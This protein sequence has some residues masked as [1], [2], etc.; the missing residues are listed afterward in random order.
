MKLGL[1]LPL[2]DKNMSDTGTFCNRNS[3]ANGHIFWKTMRKIDLSDTLWEDLE[4]R[5]VLELENYSFWTAE[6]ERCSV[7]DL[8]LGKNFLF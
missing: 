6:T 7:L 8:S 4:V 1:L 5:S 2:R 3:S